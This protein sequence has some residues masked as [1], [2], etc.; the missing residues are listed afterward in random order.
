MSSIL[1]DKNWT[2]TK[3]GSTWPAYTTVDAYFKHKQAN[4]VHP[5]EKCKAE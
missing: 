5:N 1:A 2:C 4:K 3:C